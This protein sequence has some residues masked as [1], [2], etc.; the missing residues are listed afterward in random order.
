MVSHYVVRDVS[1]GFEVV[2]LSY[3]LALSTCFVVQFVGSVVHYEKKILVELILFDFSH[4]NNAEGSVFDVVLLQL[5]LGH[6][7]HMTVA[8]SNTHRIPNSN[9][10]KLL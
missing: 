9:R 7:V 3:D 1:I 5:P 8:I 10:P 4:N 6:E 2:L